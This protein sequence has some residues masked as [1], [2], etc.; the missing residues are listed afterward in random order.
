MEVRVQ[1]RTSI[2]QGRPVACP[3]P[4]L[5]AS[6]GLGFP[7]DS[8][9]LSS[10]VISNSI[11]RSSPDSAFLGIGLERAFTEAPPDDE[12]ASTKAARREL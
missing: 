11:Q 7:T 1:I 2:I 3:N 5:S 9:A 4:R 12:G 6:R 10:L 8:K